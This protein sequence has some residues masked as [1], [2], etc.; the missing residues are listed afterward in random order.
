MYVYAHITNIPAT[1]QRGCVT[2]Q[3]KPK[4]QRLSTLSGSHTHRKGL[5]EQGKHAGIRIWFPKASLV[6]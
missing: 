2:W 1:S 6:I 5:N 3:S 4:P